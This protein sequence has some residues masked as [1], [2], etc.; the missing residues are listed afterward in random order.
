M[1]R[2]LEPTS[3]AQAINAAFGEA[4]KQAQQQTQTLPPNQAAAVVAASAAIPVVAG[5]SAGV[6]IPAVGLPPA[7]AALGAAYALPLAAAL[8][9]L[10][11]APRS[12]LVLAEELPALW[13]DSYVEGAREA[14]I[15]AA[16]GE[17]AW[18]AVLPPVPDPWRPQGDVVAQLAN[19]GLLRLLR[20]SGVWIK[21]VTDSE[22]E[23][24]GDAV[25]QGIVQGQSRAEVITAVRDIVHDEQR[26]RL[27]A[28][29]ELS[30]AR[31]AA[32]FETYA[33][34]RVDLWDLLTQP[35]ACPICVAIRE[36]NPH[37]VSDVMDRPP[38][39]PHCRC[40]PIPHIGG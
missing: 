19:G 20:Q 26:A 10:S 33:A 34:N 15:A 16:G 18:M 8:A 14:A 25:A 2:V 38:I 6:A 28:E 35:G 22:I 36:A 3:I 9:V 5:L 1:S 37:L 27:I 21:Q 39:H 31:T 29:T 7:V 23:R 12:T 24:I 11:A 13:A 17:P 32:M 40:V 4:R 30:R